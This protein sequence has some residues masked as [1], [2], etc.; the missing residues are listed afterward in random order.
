MNGV[1]PGHTTGARGKE[2][3]FTQAARRARGPGWED[4]RRIRKGRDA[5]PERDMRRRRSGR[6][7]E[8]EAQ[9]GLQDFLNEKVA[10]GEARSVYRTAGNLR[11][12]ALKIWAGEGDSSGGLARWR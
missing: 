7:L 6:W 8:A 4:G 5:Y 9:V 10:R 11:A 12:R 1:A 3:D 2:G